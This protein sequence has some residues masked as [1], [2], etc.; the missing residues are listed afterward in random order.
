MDRLE[1][2]LEQ[3]KAATAS[4]TKEV[5]GYEENLWKAQERVDHRNRTITRVEAQIEELGQ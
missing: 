3:E 1:Y 5:D 4:L 2:E